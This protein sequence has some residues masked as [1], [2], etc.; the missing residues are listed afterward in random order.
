MKHLEL[1]WVR[2]SVLIALAIAFLMSHA[3]DRR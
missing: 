3:V 2:R 1:T